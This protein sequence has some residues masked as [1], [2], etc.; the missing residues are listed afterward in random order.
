MR[1][2]IQKPIDALT[3]HR[4]LFEANFKESGHRGE[5][6]PNLDFYEALSEGTSSFC[7]VVLNDD[8]KAIGACS[9]MMIEHQ[10]TCEPTA[11]N[12]TLY[13]APEYRHGTLPGRLFLLAEKMAKTKG[14]TCFQWTCAEGFPLE[15]VL[16]KR[17][18]D[19]LTQ[20]TF[21]RAI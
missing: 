10:H 4:Q 16:R 7:I 20:I 17:A 1:Y 5:F 8:G 14:A 12:D 3:C 6:N 18:Y 21:N 13:I 15:R 19:G 9:V 11:C 2:I